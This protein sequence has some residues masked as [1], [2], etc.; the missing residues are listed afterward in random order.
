[1]NGKR[2]RKEEALVPRRPQAHPDDCQRHAAAASR[3]AFVGQLGGDAA[4]GDANA[5]RHR[6]DSC[7]GLERCGVA[8]C[9]SGRRRRLPPFF[10][11]LP[12]FFFILLLFCS[13]P[14][15]DDF[16]G[17]PAFQAQLRASLNR[18]WKRS[19]A[20]EETPAA[21]AGKTP[22]GAR[23]GRASTGKET[24]FSSFSTAHVPSPPHG[25]PSL[26]GQPPVP[27]RG[28]VSC[29]GARADWPCSMIPR[30][31]LPPRIASHH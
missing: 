30:R 18:Q 17:M 6:I 21:E 29:Q 13:L 2:R 14:A 28:P 15:A 12:F 11:A 27:G 19:I 25:R 20:D 10:S 24:G 22:F 7:A 5:E 9:C 8:A 1:M 16:A 26:Y 23:A 4:G 3:P 31:C